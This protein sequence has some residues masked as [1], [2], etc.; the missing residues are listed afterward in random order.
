M[1]RVDY[2]AENFG[3]AGWEAFVGYT[4]FD[5]PALAEIKAQEIEQKINEPVFIKFTE[6]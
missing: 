2:Y 6:L 4:M 1:I 5:I 3:Y